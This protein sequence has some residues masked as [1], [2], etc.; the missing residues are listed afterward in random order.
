MNRAADELGGL[1]AVFNIAGMGSMKH[2]LEVTEEEWNRVLR[3]NLTGTTR[4][5]R[6]CSPSAAAPS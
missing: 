5:C 3:V 2:T 6:T 1:Y 4:R